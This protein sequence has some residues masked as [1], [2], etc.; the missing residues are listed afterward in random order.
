MGAKKMQQLVRLIVSGGASEVHK[1]RRQR[2]GY[3]HKQKEDPNSQRGVMMAAGA[4]T[5][6]RSVT[7]RRRSVPLPAA[8]PRAE[9]TASKGTA[10][11]RGRRWRTRTARHA[12]RPGGVSG[13]DSELYVGAP[14]TTMTPP[15]PIITITTIGIRQALEATI[16]TAAHR[17]M[18]HPQRAAAVA[19]RGP[20]RVVMAAAAGAS[21]G[22]KAA[23]V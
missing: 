10:M 6:V 1:K 18:I 14:L 12:A 2:G 16:I 17:A 20:P 7:R 19:A 4:P 3:T 15:M 23:A 13:T 8:A 11:G 9:T 21:G 22:P 5:V